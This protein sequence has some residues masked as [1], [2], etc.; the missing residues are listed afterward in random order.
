MRTSLRVIVFSLTLSSTFVV[1]GQSTKSFTA[2]NPEVFA[3]IQLP[4]GFTKNSAIFM[5]IRN[6]GPQ[7]KLISASSD[8]SGTAEFWRYSTEGGQFKATKVDGI[9]IAD[10]G[11]IEFKR[12][13]TVL[14]LKDVKKAL[15]AGE[16]VPVKL[17]FEKGGDLDVA[18]PVKVFNAASMNPPASLSPPPSS[19]ASGKL[20]LSDAKKKCIELGFKTDTEPFGKCVLRLSK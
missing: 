9:D 4:T 2:E 19:D 7:D 5:V 11:M 18:V 8:A 13:Q 6:N 17:T 16:T 20:D 1:F 12:G 3:S 14:L 15:V 10:H